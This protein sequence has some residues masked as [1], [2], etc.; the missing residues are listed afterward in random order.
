MTAGG[1]IYNHRLSAIA[2]MHGTLYLHR[3]HSSF[4]TDIFLGLLLTGRAVEH[5]QRFLLTLRPAMTT[6]NHLSPKYSGGVVAM[7]VLFQGLLTWRPSGKVI[8]A[9]HETSGTDV[10]L[11]C[12]LLYLGMLRAP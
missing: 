8:M 4:M 7:A 10:H 5:Q 2:L 12:T 3:F 11:S 9:F 6:P 1:P